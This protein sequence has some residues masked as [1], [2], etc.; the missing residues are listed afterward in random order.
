MRI[1]LVS[2]GQMPTP[3][4]DS[5]GLQRVVYDLGRM[6]LRRGHAVTLVGAEGSQL[7]GATVVEACPPLLGQVAYTEKQVAEAALR[8]EYDVLL[9]VSHT[10]RAA[11]AEP[12][13]SVLFHQDVTPVAKH[14]RP[15]FISEDQRYRTYKG[16]HGYRVIHNKLLDPPVFSPLMPDGPH[17]V[18]KHDVALFLGNIVPHKGVHLAIYIAL[19]L[20]IPLWVGGPMLDAG[21]ADRVEKLCDGT[22][23]L[24]IGA[25]NQDE[26]Y[27][28]LAQARMTICVP[29]QSFIHYH[30]TAQLVAMES[31][32]V[33]TPVLASANGGMPEYVPQATGRCGKTLKQMIALADEVWNWPDRTTVAAYAQRHFDLMTVA[34]EWEGLLRDAAKC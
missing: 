30:E 2:D 1:T 21:Y 10:H 3:T 7:E 29:N 25:L 32:W 20:G 4:P 18:Q 22:K 15:V 34:D 23:V 16:K 33:G 13:R 11:Y 9:D 26:K 24:Y 5:G 31:A 28:A 27:R 14:P 17:A 8:T 12:E 19:K 6:L